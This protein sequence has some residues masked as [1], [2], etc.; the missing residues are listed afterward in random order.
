MAILGTTS[1]MPA[2][3]AVSARRRLVA[4]LVG[5]SVADL[6]TTASALSLGAVERSPGGAM[7]LAGLGL[8]G[9]V[10]LKVLAVALVWLLDRS[11]PAVGKGVGWGL[12]ALTFMAVSW[13]MF[14]LGGA[15]VRF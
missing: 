2:P 15:A 11:W 10:L 4:V 13:N 1:T 3:R 5:L 7:L 6:A 9:L 12:V 8:A 14:A